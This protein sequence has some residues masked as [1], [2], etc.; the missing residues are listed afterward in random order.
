MIHDLPRRASVLMWRQRE[1]IGEDLCRLRPARGE[2][3]RVGAPADARELPKRIGNDPKIGGSPGLR[4]VEGPVIV[5]GPRRHH[6]SAIRPAERLDQAD[7]PALNRSHRTESRARQKYIA[8]L[9]A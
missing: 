7:G 9:H 2:G 8:L 4:R 5:V 3:E 6:H 1:R